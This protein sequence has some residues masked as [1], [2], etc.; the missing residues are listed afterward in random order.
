MDSAFDAFVPGSEAPWAPISS[1][2][3]IVGP[4]MFG[5]AYYSIQK[6]CLKQPHGTWDKGWLKANHN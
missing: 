3:E 5:E 6:T 1:I 4:L 2:L